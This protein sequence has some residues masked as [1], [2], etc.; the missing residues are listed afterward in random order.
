MCVADL[1]VHRSIPEGK[2]LRLWVSWDIF[3]DWVSRRCPEDGYVMKRRYLKRQRLSA[4]ALSA[5]LFPCFLGPGNVMAQSVKQ[6]S[7][8][9][10]FFA[11]QSP[12]KLHRLV[13]TEK[14]DLRI[15]A[16]GIE[17]QS[18]SHG[19]QKW[20][21]E[22]IQTF[23]LSSRSLAIESY[24]NRR[25]HLPGIERY[26]F[27]LDQPVPPMIAAELATAVQRPSQ[28]GVP[29]V[30]SQSL[31]IPA[32][33][34]ALTGG[35]NGVLRVREDGIDYVSS[36]ASDSRSWRW[37]DLETVSNPDPWHLLVYAYRDTCV[38]DLKERVSR[39]TLNHIS[40]EIWTHNDSNVREG[41]PAPPNE[42][43]T[44]DVRRSDE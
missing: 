34:R 19:T 16:N 26:K 23:R 30:S 7:G 15:G 10:S 35:T 41:S 40:D 6:P 43:S 38:F 32:H 12:A 4:L 20:A 21:F 36:T 11:W 39:E 31:A 14:G 8:E 44:K 18:A 24:Q 1:V 28:N 33:H 17:F 5:S 13:G 22:D 25:L 3:L 27:D 37:A 9:Q 2:D 29:D 42:S